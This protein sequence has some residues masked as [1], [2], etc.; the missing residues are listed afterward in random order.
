MALS[1]QDAEKQLFDLLQGGGEEE[2]KD[3]TDESQEQ[4]AQSQEDTETESAADETQEEV[5][6]SEEDSGEEEQAQPQEAAAEETQ[7]A[8]EHP[9]T[10]DELAEHLEVD[11]EYLYGLQ[12]P[13]GRDG[14]TATLGE[15]KNTAI[16]QIDAER[17]AER[18]KSERQQFEQQRQELMGQLHGRLSEADNLIKGFEAQL[19]EELKS[20][21]METLRREDPA[22][23]TAKRQEIEERRRQLHEQR[24]KVRENAT[25]MTEEQRKEFEAKRQQHLQREGAK[26]VEAIP[27]WKDQERAKTES[28]QLVSYL[29][30]MG[31]TDEEIGQIGDHRFFVLARKAMLFDEGE[32]KVD[33]AKKKVKTL[34]KRVK[35]SSPKKPQDAE[36][37]AR[38]K[39]MQRFQKSK[40]PQDAEAVL[41]DMIRSK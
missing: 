3:E 10:L 36:T 29:R 32:K 1:P 18:L 27:E 14:K 23:W 40:T 34:P 21:E 41:L 26:L 12:V 15:L 5:T 28:Q 20:P 38:K 16:A 37:E 30:G 2:K 19:D 7:E 24:N 8:G 4:A 6:A 31:A 35:P 11:K 9:S 33:V 17:E 13:V 22:E 39:R 25:S